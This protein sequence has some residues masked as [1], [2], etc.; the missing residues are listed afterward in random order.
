MKSH[1]KFCT[2][3]VYEIHIYYYE[4]FRLSQKLQCS[5]VCFASVY[6]SVRNFW[7]LF[8][9][10]LIYCTALLSQVVLYPFIFWHAFYSFSSAILIFE[11]SDFLLILALLYCHSMSS[12]T[13]L[14]ALFFFWNYSPSKILFLLS[15]SVLWHSFCYGTLSSEAE[16]NGLIN[17]RLRSDL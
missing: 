5:F 7:W 8:Y 17:R 2:T 14:L 12:V 11:S 16:F 10:S 15:L 6:L 4:R 1:G 13:V 3:I 9:V